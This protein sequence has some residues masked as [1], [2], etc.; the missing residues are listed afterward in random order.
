MMELTEERHGD[1]WEGLMSVH[2]DCG[3]ETATCQGQW[4]IIFGYAEL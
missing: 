4:W 1:S 3:K 2:V